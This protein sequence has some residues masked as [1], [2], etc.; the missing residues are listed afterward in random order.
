MGKVEGIIKSEI[1]RLAKREM[2]KSFGPLSQDVRS[3]KGTLSQLRKT[4]I[5]L[6]RFVAQQEKERRGQKLPLE[7]PRKR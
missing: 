3:L 5:G 7:A 2:K 1:V 4:V 6:Q